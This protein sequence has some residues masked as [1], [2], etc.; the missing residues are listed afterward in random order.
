MAK[1]TAKQSIMVAKLFGLHAS[2]S[3]QGIEAA[4]QSWKKGAPLKASGGKLVI[5]AETDVTLILG[6]ALGD[7]SGVTDKKANLTPALPHVVFQAEL[8]D[9]T[10]GAYTLLQTDLYGDFGLNVAGDGKW[11]VDADEAGAEQAVTIIGF[12]DP[13]GTNNAIVYFVFKNTTTIFN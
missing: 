2:P 10:D 9:L 4:S 6:I 5:A 1:A 3:L 13:V 8:S 7:A 11:F 12:K